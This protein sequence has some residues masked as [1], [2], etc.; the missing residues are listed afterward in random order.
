MVQTCN[1][2]KNN[3]THS[4]SCYPSALSRKWIIH[5]FMFYTAEPGWSGTGTSQ[6][7]TN[8]MRQTVLLHVQFQKTL[9]TVLII[10]QRLANLIKIIFYSQWTCRSG[11][12]AL[13][14]NWPPVAAEQVL[15]VYI[16][17]LCFCA[18]LFQLWHELGVKLYIT[19]NSFTFSIQHYT[20][21]NAAH[22]TPHEI[23][24]KAYQLLKWDITIFPLDTPSKL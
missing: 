18:G 9:D 8:E 1:K 21:I 20:S 6:R 22:P 24:K 4:S 2:Y 5:T 23:K 14:Y 15:E 10:V 12:F 3:S 11:S 7:S 13:R 17:T 19:T 16:T